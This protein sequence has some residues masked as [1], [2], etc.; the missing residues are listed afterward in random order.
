MIM[1]GILWGYTSIEQ[2]K[3]SMQQTLDTDKQ[4]EDRS[5]EAVDSKHA[6][7]RMFR[8]METTEKVLVG[9]ADLS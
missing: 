8:N 6:S 9:V 4:R 7:L 5:Q 1:M 3:C 2:L